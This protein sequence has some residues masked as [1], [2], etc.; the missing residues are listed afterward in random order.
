MELLDTIALVAIVELVD[1]VIDWASTELVDE[2]ED[3]DT[4]VGVLIEVEDDTGVVPEVVSTITDVDVAV[5]E[6]SPSE[7]R[8][9]WVSMLLV[10]DEADFVE[11]SEEVITLDEAMVVVCSDDLLEDDG[12]EDV[13]VVEEVADVDDS[14][15]PDVEVAVEDNVEVVSVEDE[16][17]EEIVSEDST[18]DDDEVVNVVVDVLVDV[19]VGAADDVVDDVV[20][21]VDDDDVLVDEVV[22]DV[23]GYRVASTLAIAAAISDDK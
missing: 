23:E 15:A 1:A 17:V 19:V 20:G 11:P 21:T 13:M 14:T 7:L 16:D 3:D 2:I 9:D 5:L 12:V 22:E 18:K 4:V 10:N 8:T 6:V